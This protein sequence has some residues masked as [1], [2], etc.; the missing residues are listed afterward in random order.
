MVISHGSE[1]LG[2]PDKIDTYAQAL[3]GEGILPG[4]VESP[5]Q[6][7][8]IFLRGGEDL[9]HASDYQVC[10]VFA[11]GRGEF[12]RIGGDEATDQMIRA[13]RERNIRALYLRPLVS[14]PYQGREL[15]ATMS[16]IGS[17][18][19]GLV[20]AGFSIGTAVPFPAV[21]V[22]AWPIAAA[23]AGVLA[24]VALIAQPLWPGSAGP[25][26]VLWVIGLAGWMTVL[27]LNPIWARLAAGLGA[28]SV[29][30]VV[31]VL[32][33]TSVVARDTPGRGVGRAITA[34]VIASVCSLIGAALM[35]GILA[36]SRFLLEFD[37]FRG[38]RLSYLLPLAI[39]C[40]LL[41][42]GEDSRARP[43]IER[44]YRQS[45]ELLGREMSARDMIAVA[46]ILAVAYVYLGR[47]G[48]EGGLPVPALELMTRQTLERL[49]SVRP[50]LKEFLIG[51][52]ALITGSILYAAGRIRGR[53][54]WQLAAVT[55]QVSIINSF[56]HL[57]TPFLLSLTRTAHGVWLGAAVGI[58][59][60]LIALA[61]GRAGARGGRRRS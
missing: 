55:G 60:A 22:A 47:A 6:R 41:A 42:R 61:F 25:R 50:R 27:H 2:Y 32:T 37:Y 4:L 14:R 7:G 40:V 23:G 56:S 57:R 9:A 21:S 13:V 44:L 46:A 16:M 58:A 35:T 3:R 43:A 53:S 11:I 26:F 1:C 45:R 52:P 31:A 51:H 24:A 48:H 38:V 39:L 33:G 15:D 20:A 18:R 30:P 19:D 49:L 12:D 28:A 29:F 8:F 17:L 34:L 54:I 10:R 5:L 59:V 36:D